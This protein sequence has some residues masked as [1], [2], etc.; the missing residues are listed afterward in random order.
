MLLS[1]IL[2]ILLKLNQPNK[3][4]LNTKNLTTL[5]KLESAHVIGKL[6]SF[7]SAGYFQ[8]RVEENP[9]AV[10]S[11]KETLWLMELLQ[12][13]WQRIQ[14]TT[15]CYTKNSNLVVNQ[16]CVALAEGLTDTLYKS[17]LDILMPKLSDNPLLH[18]KVELL[19]I[20]S[21]L[22]DEEGIALFCA[23]KSHFKCI[24]ELDTEDQTSCISILSKSKIGNTYLVNTIK[25][26][27][28]DEKNAINEIMSQLESQKKR[29][30]DS[31]DEASEQSSNKKAKLDIPDQPAIYNPLFLSEIEDDVVNQLAA[32]NTLPLKKRPHLTQE[33]PAIE[34]PYTN[35]EAEITPILKTTKN[36][37]SNKQVVFSEYHLEKNM[38]TFFKS[39]NNKDF[40]TVK[41]ASLSDVTVYVDMLSNLQIALEENNHEAQALYQQAFTWLEAVKSNLDANEKTLD[42]DTQD[43]QISWYIKQLKHLENYKHQ[44]DA[45]KPSNPLASVEIAVN[46]ATTQTLDNTLCSDIELD[47]YADPIQFFEACDVLRNKLEFMSDKP[48]TVKNAL[49]Y[50]MQDFMSTK[51]SVLT[52]YYAINNTFDL[53]YI[54][55]GISVFNSLA[56][57]FHL[58]TPL[59]KNTIEKIE[60]L[61][62]ELLKNYESEKQEASVSWFINH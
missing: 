38:N 22:S 36:S 34:L 33:L 61:Y 19:F 27:K 48:K 56:D 11:D 9:E 53:M 1:K 43:R 29:S 54:K 3:I 30:L 55:H 50:C 12:S 5:Q 52:T 62:N 42:L 15:S 59:Y 45:L 49:F 41:S 25:S 23:K 16:I 7:A 14:K 39:S 10:L 47:N 13:R 21:I 4:T 40:T 2:N 57:T 51:L 6:E 26:L 37:N 58:K 20:Q 32:L 17:Y 28:R 18:N 44:I 35:E 24:L 31:D 8:K 60:M 46:S